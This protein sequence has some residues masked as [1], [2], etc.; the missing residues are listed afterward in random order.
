MSENP[1]N[2]TVIQGILD[3]HANGDEAAKDELIKFAME[4]LRRLARKMLRENAA[5]KRWNDTDDVLQNAL[6]RLHRAL[7]TER[8]E[9]TQRFISL[10]AMQIRREL[11]DL[12]R[13]F[14]GP[15]GHGARYISD[16]GDGDP[17]GNR[18]PLHEPAGAN[19]GP[20]DQV[21]RE[22]DIHLAVE[23][24]PEEMQV[25]VDRSIYLGMTQE[26]I[27]QELGI[28]TKTVKRRWRE[29]RLKLEQLLSPR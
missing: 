28:S 7:L 11:I 27:A 24:L 22:I 17:S 5:V 15:A 26:E 25:L 16:P 18:R 3:R 21:D 20:E 29:A 9:T 23:K 8:P 6:V 10:A 13:H 1:G 4:R 2:T 14:Y 12:W 19:T